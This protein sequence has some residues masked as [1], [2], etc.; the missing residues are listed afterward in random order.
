[1]AKKTKGKRHYLNQLITAEQ[2]VLMSVKLGLPAKWSAR[3]NV[4][5][6]KDSYTALIDV[7]EHLRGVQLLPDCVSR[8]ELTPGEKSLLPRKK[9][10]EAF[11]AKCERG[12]V[13]NATELLDLMSSIVKFPR[14]NY[15]E[16]VCALSLIS[17]RGLPE[18]LGSAKFSPCEES[19]HV[20]CVYAGS[21][22]VRILSCASLEILLK[23]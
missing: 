21:V 20:G 3:R 23:V 14:A 2:R 1:M 11:D 18:L 6:R 12:V 22:A 4:C 17:G 9:R 7:D 19:G 15:F 16:L 13:V 10:R 8:L 5:S